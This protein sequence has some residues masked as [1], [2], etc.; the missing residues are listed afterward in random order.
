MGEIQQIAMGASAWALLAVLAV[1]CEAA[2]GRQAQLDA[3][4]AFDL[5]QEKEG[6]DLRKDI[7]LDATFKAVSAVQKRLGV[8][9]RQRDQLKYQANDLM[10]VEMHMLENLKTQVLK[11]KPLSKEVADKRYQETKQHRQE[12]D[13][14]VAE[15][16]SEIIKLKAE[17]KSAVAKHQTA[18]RAHEAKDKA[19][20]VKFL[21]ERSHKRNVQEQKQK[22]AAEKAA[23]TKAK[24][25]SQAAIAAKEKDEQKFKTEEKQ[26]LIDTE[27][28]KMD[29]VKSELSKANLLKQ[30]AVSAVKAAA[31]TLKGVSDEKAYKSYLNM[32][33]KSV[34]K[35]E[36]K[37][38]EVK[39]VEKKKEKV[40]EGLAKDRAKF[41]EVQ[42][43]QLEAHKKA[44]EN[45]E[46]MVSG[47]ENRNCNKMCKLYRKA[48]DT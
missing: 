22:A 28:K 45:H 16:K 34:H 40:Q 8:A 9:E 20:K 17:L 13:A 10:E 12:K 14:Q 38:S 18:A 15:K 19:E 30:N 5:L 43:A 1:A 36:R 3:S 47:R 44:K 48:T 24:E 37:I 11:Q 27:K 25:A 33:K 23:K 4:K 46:K 42:K 6:A 32:Y 26:R 21:N 2:G 29:A 7:D 41:K 39:T 35:E 31:K